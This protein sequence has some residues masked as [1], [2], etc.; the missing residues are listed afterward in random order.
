MAAG[1][2]LLELGEEARDGALVDGAVGV[3][4]PPDPPDPVDPPTPAA[5]GMVVVL[6]DCRLV[7]V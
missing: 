7:D 6:E 5:P 3:A 4:D 1:D 2:E